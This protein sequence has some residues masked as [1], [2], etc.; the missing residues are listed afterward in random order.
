MIPVTAA[1]QQRYF[2]FVAE[3]ADGATVAQQRPSRS[4]QWQSRAMS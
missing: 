3:T 2:V 4:A 1:L